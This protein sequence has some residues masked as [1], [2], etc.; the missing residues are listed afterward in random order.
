MN[1][2]YCFSYLLPAQYKI[3]EYNLPNYVSTTTDEIV[4]NISPGDKSYNNNFGDKLIQKG[5][6]SGLVWNDLNSNGIR[7]YSEPKL[8]N[9]IVKLYDCN[10]NWIKDLYTDINGNYKF[11]SLDSGTYQILVQL[12]DGYSFSPANQG[13]DDSKDSD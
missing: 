6:I 10:N 12:P 8:S 3:K 4:K 1:G 9:I 11:H 13:R 2:E 5:S 7:E